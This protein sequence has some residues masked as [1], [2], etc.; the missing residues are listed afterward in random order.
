MRMTANI[1]S[2]RRKGN[3]HFGPRVGGRQGIMVSEF[4]TLG[5]ILRVP[6]HVSGE[7]L[8]SN[9]TWP[10]MEGKPVREGLQDLKY[11]KDNYWT[12]EKMVEH[13]TRVAIPIF[14]YVSSP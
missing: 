1:G 5:G 8:S 13:T 14:K 9:P 11:G 12:G 4:L 3:N 6:D 7:E 10:Q 2:G